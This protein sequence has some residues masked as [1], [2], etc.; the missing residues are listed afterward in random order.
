[1]KKKKGL[2]G[3]QRKMRSHLMNSPTSPVE[4][5][6]KSFLL[7][8]K[9]F[10]HTL[11]NVPQVKPSWGQSSFKFAEDTDAE[12][13]WI[14]N[15]SCPFFTGVYLSLKDI[16]TV[17]HTMT[18]GVVT[19]LLSIYSCEYVKNVARILSRLLKMTF[20][21]GF[22]TKEVGQTGWGGTAISLQSSC[23]PEVRANLKRKAVADV[24]Q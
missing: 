10:C 21:V 20:N 18:Q 12:I 16:F 1:M 7:A 8:C 3:D 19:F 15:L 5:L 2:L 23:R 24:I 9:S 13:C 11:T 6:L 4:Q 14:K 17:S 22:W